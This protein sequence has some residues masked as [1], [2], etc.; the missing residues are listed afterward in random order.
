MTVSN[1]FVFRFADV[2]VR[3]SE[4]SIIRS[5]QVFAVE[6]KAF[7][8][9]LFLVRNPQRVVTKEELLG[10]VSGDAAVTENS[11]TRSILKLRRVL[12]DD[13]REPKYIETVATVGYRL[14]CG[15]RSS[16]Q[17]ADHLDVSRYGAAA[18][19]TARAGQEEQHAIDTAIPLEESKNSP[20]N[21]EILPDIQPSPPAWFGLLWILTALLVLFAFVAAIRYLRRPLPQPHITSYT[22]LTHDNR[23]KGLFAAD[24]SR[25][26]LTFY[27]GT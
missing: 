9:L 15:V 1:S 14:I 25:L 22:Q 12:N 4:F 2:E 17:I 5:G 27:G 24:S 11:L 21:A 26:Y 16:E 8:V 7:R 23:R 13:A 3:E 10:A 18:T 19:A 20:A 6:P